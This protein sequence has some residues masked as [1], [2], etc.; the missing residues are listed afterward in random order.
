MP[1]SAYQIATTGFGLIADNSHSDAYSDGNK[2]LDG[3][4]LNLD[5]IR[6]AVAMKCQAFI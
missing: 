1:V 2:H 5:V 3:K 6:D 4:C